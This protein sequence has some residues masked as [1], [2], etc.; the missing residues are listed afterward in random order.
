MTETIE[1]ALEAVESTSGVAVLDRAFALLGA[2][3]VADAR[4]TLTELSRRTG[5]YKSTVLRLLGALEHGG[6]IR[7]TTDGLYAIGP[8]PL[9]LAAIY[10]GSFSVAQA[11]EP[12]L[13][14]LSMTSGETASFYIRRNEQRVVLF[15]AEPPR[16]VRFSIRVGEAF[17]LDQGA[18]GKVLLS[19]ASGISAARGP[20][21]LWRVSY[22]ER[23]P[24]TASLA[25]PIFGITGDL[26]GALT[27]SGP[28]SRMVAPATMVKHCGLLLKVAR[29][30]VASLGGNESIYETACARLDEEL[31]STDVAQKV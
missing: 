29:R 23:D 6:Y 15:R 17:R 12:L 30:A 19:F 10:Q 14:Q 3:G 31:F 21:P 4:L 8:E 25:V 13:G 11:V 16:T 26:Q 24:E 27:L 28:K 7:K 22:G 5:L 2:F 18:S 1:A 20:T 9:R